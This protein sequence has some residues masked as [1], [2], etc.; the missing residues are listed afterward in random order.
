M[1]SMEHKQSIEFYNGGDCVTFQTEFLSKQHLLKILVNPR[2]WLEL[3]FKSIEFL[4]FGFIDF[5]DSF[6]IRSDRSSLIAR[7][8]KWSIHLIFWLLARPIY[9]LKLIE[10]CFYYSLKILNQ[11]F[12]HYFK[13]IFG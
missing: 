8:M 10:N 9:L 6:F 2:W 1:L 3:I 11:T 7:T 13:N 4:L 5:I 12:V